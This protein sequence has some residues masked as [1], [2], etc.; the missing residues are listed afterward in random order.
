MVKR[1]EVL[2]VI[3]AVV[4]IVMVVVVFFNHDWGNVRCRTS[5]R[6]SRGLHEDIATTRPIRRAVVYSTKSSILKA[7]IGREWFESSASS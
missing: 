5:I 4:V 1:V 7:C 6:C 2:L 3:V